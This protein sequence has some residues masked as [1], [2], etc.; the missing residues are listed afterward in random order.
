MAIRRLM[1]KAGTAG[2]LG[3]FILVMTIMG[4][5][6]MKHYPPEDFFHGTQLSLAQAIEEGNER[7]VVT[8][9]KQTALNQPGAQDMTLLFY[10]LQT[11]FGERKTQLRILTTLVKSGAN[12][13]QQVPDVGSVAE[14]VAKSPHPEYMQALLDGGMSPEIMIEDTPIIMDASNDESLPVLSLL[15]ERGAN[16]N[17]RD[18]LGRTALVEALAGFQLEAVNWLLDHGADPRV[19]MHNGSSFASMLSF[20]QSKKGRSEADEKRLQAIIRKAMAH[21]MKWPAEDR[22]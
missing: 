17:Q 9:A 15:V 10:A 18:S 21:G 7:E 12:P 13:V 16:V 1:A 11:A 8:L 19:Q 22:R 20:I 3:L 6:G 2:C 14:V 4:C 5:D